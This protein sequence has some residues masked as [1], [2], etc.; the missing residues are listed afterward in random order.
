MTRSELFLILDSAEDIS[1]KLDLIQQYF[2]IETSYME[3]MRD[4]VEK[5]KS[6]DTNY[7]I[8]G[9][10]QVE[11]LNNTKGAPIT[12]QEAADFRLSLSTCWSINALIGELERWEA[13]CQRDA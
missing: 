9:N 10:E 1:V 5:A 13:R 8:F 7:Q 12:L 11:K 6:G 3:N 2:G 4:A